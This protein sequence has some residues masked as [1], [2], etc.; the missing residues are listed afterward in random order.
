M[1]IISV[2]VD[3]RINAANVLAEF[4]IEEYLKSA[5]SMINNNPFQR[6]TVKSSGTVYS[7]LRDDLKQGCII[8]PIVLALNND[9]LTERNSENEKT[10]YKNYIENNIK[11][12]LI[13]DGLQRTNNIIDANDELQKENDPL[14]LNKYLNYKIR[15]EIYF[16]IN[17][18]GILYRMLTLNTGQTPMSIRHQIEILYSD[19]LK[20]PTNGIRLIRE[21]D[22]GSKGFG[23]YSFKDVIEGLTSYLMRDYLTFD[24]GDVLENIKSLEKL[25]KENQGADIFKGYLELFHSFLSRM[26]FLLEGW[27]YRDG[28]SEYVLNSAPF[29]R[30]ALSIFSKSQIMTGLGAGIAFL[31]DRELSD[32]TKVKTDIERINFD[33][34]AGSVI[35]YLLSKLDDLKVNAAKIGNAQREYFY[36][37]F[38]ELFNPEGDSY[39]SIDKS[40]ESAFKRYRQNN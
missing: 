27:Q 37:F 19:Y 22:S 11:E 1:D 32:F 30:D 12:A 34:N 18:I 13:L 4:T 5:D 28:E 29:G 31:K 7:L 10:I 9:P 23:R 25:S 14:A 21:I 20:Q 35:Y 17:K 6:K 38:R 40:I 8:P 16:G 24:R 2:L 39:L 33:Y 3:H 15:V 26:M 36:Y